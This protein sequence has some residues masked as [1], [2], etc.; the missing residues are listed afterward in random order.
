M[1]TIYR[2]RSSTYIDITD[3]LTFLKDNSFLLTSEKEGFNQIY[4]YS[5]EGLLIDK[6]TKDSFDIENIQGVD[7]LKKRIYFRAWNP[8]P[9]TKRVYSINFKGS[10]LEHYG[11]IDSLTNNIQ[12]C[13]NFQ[14]GVLTETKANNAPMY[15]VINAKNKLVKSIELN[16]ELTKKLSTLSFAQKEFMEIKMNGVSLSCWMI[17]PKDFSVNKRYPVL[18]TIYSGPGSQTVKNEYGGGMDAW[19]QYLASKG[20]IIVSV[21]NRGTGGKGDTFK[22]CTYKK[23]GL[24]ESD[25]IVAVA[26]YLTTFPYIDKSRIG[27]YGWSFGGYMS[28]MCLF[29]G[30]DVFKTAVA[31]APVTDWRY[32]DNIYT[33]RFMQ[34]EV[35]NKAGYDETSLMTYCKNLNDKQKYLLIHGTFDDNVHPQNSFMLLK[36]LINLNKKYDSEFYPDKSHGIS[37]GLT[38]LHIYTRITEYILNNL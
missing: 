29:R 5:S 31:V 6:I 30:A 2:E 11:L 8:S 4:Y 38:R 17:K 27:I 1:K 28:S 16:D 22:K 3:N 9:T 21:D 34:R 7:E 19:Y 24:I 32:Y 23:L 18:F 15:N 26:K 13:A 37:G 35:E 36:S 10:G 25:D 12:W 14:Y 20:Y 33:E